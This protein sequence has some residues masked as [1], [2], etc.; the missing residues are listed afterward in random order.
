MYNQTITLG[1]Y[2]ESEDTYNLLVINNVEVQPIY[3]VKEDISETNDT[4]KVLVI[5]MYS[6]DNNGKYITA[7]GNKIYYRAPKHW[8]ENEEYFTLQC[9]KDFILLGEYHSE[10]PN[11]NLNELKNKNDDIF[12]INRIDDFQDDLSH[13]EIICN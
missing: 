12:I 7:S 3:S 6:I 13:F 9:G 5:I 8:G 11:I 10:D 4:S 2:L 1:N